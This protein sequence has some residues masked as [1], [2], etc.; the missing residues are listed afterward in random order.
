MW[1]SWLLKWYWKRIFFGFPIWSSFHHCSLLAY[2]WSPRCAITITR[3]HI[4]T[5]LILTLVATSLTQYLAGYRERNL[6]FY[7]LRGWY[8]IIKITMNPNFHLS[9][10]FPSFF[11]SISTSIKLFVVWIEATERENKNTKLQ[12]ISIYFFGDIERRV[13]RGPCP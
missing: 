9:L 4:I 11:V 7:R 5:S 12:C 2:H 13:G 6:G 3:Q 10:S 1:D 8:S